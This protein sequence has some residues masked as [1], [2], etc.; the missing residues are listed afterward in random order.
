M[1]FEFFK[2]QVR[3]K[4]AL[5][6]IDKEEGIS[7]MRLSNLL[8]DIPQATLYRHVN[9]MQQDQLIKVVSVQ[10]LDRGEEKLYALNTEEYRISDEEWN[11]ASYSE[12]VKFISY[13]F[14]YIMQSYKNYYNTLTTEN[15]IDKSTFSL[16]KLNLNDN[17]FEKFQCEI[18]ELLNK[19]YSIEKHGNSKERII[20]FV[21]IPE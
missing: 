17:E 8:K 14:M 2:N 12:K 15:N 19:F 3:F 11:S 5:E 4:I 21:I 18:S 9:S 13:Y 7:I 1:E 6:L 20:S 10:K 16:T